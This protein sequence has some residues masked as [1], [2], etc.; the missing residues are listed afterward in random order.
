MCAITLR[1]RKQ[2]INIHFHTNNHPYPQKQY[3]MTQKGLLSY[4]DFF[5]Q[6]FTAT[7]PHLLSSVVIRAFEFGGRW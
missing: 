2:K 3:F 6:H 4:R 5:Q 7:S 1:L